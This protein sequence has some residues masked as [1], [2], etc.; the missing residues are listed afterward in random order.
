MLAGWLTKASV[1]VQLLAASLNL[2]ALNVREEWADGHFSWFKH[3]F[4][5]HST[6]VLH[7]C[8]PSVYLIFP[9]DSCVVNQ[10][11][12]FDIPTV[13]NLPKFELIR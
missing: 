3:I 11:K 7:E 1:N 9:L 4:S 12:R 10:R 2:L 6:Q 8:I 13:E 5:T